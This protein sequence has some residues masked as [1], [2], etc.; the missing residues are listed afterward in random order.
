MLRVQLKIKSNEDFGGKLEKERNLQKQKFQDESVN[1]DI[2]VYRRA[3]VV[4]VH[5]GG[6]AEGLMKHKMKANGM[7][8]LKEPAINA[9]CNA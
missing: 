7:L 2:I 1:T 8:G 4:P 9:Q 5:C 3:L 6:K